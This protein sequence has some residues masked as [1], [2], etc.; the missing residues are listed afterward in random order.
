MSRQD[1]AVTSGCQD[2]ARIKNV[3][4]RVCRTY[5][6]SEPTTFLSDQIDPRFDWVNTHFAT[7]AT[8]DSGSNNCPAVTRKSKCFIVRTRSAAET[9]DMSRGTRLG[10]RRHHRYG[11]DRSKSTSKAAAARD[12]GGLITV[13]H[14]VK[15]HVTVLL[16]TRTAWDGLIKQ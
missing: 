6:M 13:S 4:L 1:D 7:T 10:G 8:H 16:L 12:S 2:K 15:L 14:L 3:E 11:W 9:K 5:S